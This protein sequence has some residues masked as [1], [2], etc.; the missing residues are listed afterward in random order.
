MV[1]T[2]GLWLLHVPL[3]FTLGL[4]T[5]FMIFIPYIGSLIALAVTLLVALIQG[6]TQV[7]YVTIL[8]LGVHIAEG[9][10]L[11]PMVQRR[12]VYL[13]PALTILSQVVMGMLLGFLGLALATPLTA[14]VLVLVEML[15]LRESPR[16]H[17]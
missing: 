6:P 10:L 9:Y 12:A 7:L 16:H 8:F 14:A 5:A 15:Y 13:P 11:T 4:L 3:A 17:G 1:T 2:I